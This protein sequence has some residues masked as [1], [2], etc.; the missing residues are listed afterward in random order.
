MGW[1][2][3]YEIPEEDAAVLKSLLGIKSEAV[4]PEPV[5]QQYIAVRQ[6]AD[7]A[8]MVLT[9]H[10]LLNI[11]LHSTKVEAKEPPPPTIAELWDRGE[12][13]RETKVVCQMGDR[14]K[15]KGRLIAVNFEQECTVATDDGEEYTLPQE[16][17]QL[18]SA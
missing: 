6:I 15:K 3:D 17:V 16:K 18:V 7:R 12:I 13:G 8:T 11:V 4:I 1:M 5:R 14:K 9:H 10:E 2:E